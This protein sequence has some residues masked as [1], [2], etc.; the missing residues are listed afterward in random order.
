MTTAEDVRKLPIDAD[1]KYIRPPST[2]RNKIEKGGKFEPEKG[3]YHLY[4]AYVCPWANRTLI[5][6]NLKGLQD[7]IC[8][9]RLLVGFCLIAQALQAV[10]ICTSR[11]DT[12]GW[13]FDDTDPAF[14]GAQLEPFYGFGHIRDLY[15]KVEPNFD[16]RSTVPVLWDK[17]LETIVSNE[18]SEILRILNTAFNDI[19][20]E[21]LYPEALREEIDALNEWVYSDINNGVYKS[22]FSRTQGAYEE[23]VKGV[24]AGL[25]R[26][27]K[28]LADGSKDYLIGNTLTEADIRLFVTAIRFDVAYNG[29]FK[30]NIRT[31]RSG[32]P[33]I[34]RWMKDLYWKNKSFSETVDFQHIKAGYYNRPEASRMLFYEVLLLTVSATV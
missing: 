24:F 6:R 13:R 28:I 17:K 23:A 9:S 31:I 34:N 10:T 21:N 26:V 12:K 2:F 5:A 11:M 15:L 7:I 27:E 14:P 32:Y 29:Q 25:D 18:S 16:G 1:G 4:V 3:R 33:N 8:A 22:G 30:C 19:I 20:P